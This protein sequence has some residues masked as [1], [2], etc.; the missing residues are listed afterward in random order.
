VDFVV[1]QRWV[2][3]AE[4]ELGLGLVSR[5]EGRRVWLGFPAAGTER[6][7]ALASAPIK[8]VV[9]REGDEVSDGAGRVLR[10]ESVEE[11]NGLL[12][13][14][15][16]GSAIREN[17]LSS[18]IRF[19]KP[20]ERLIGGLWDDNRAFELRRQA[21]ELHHAIARS[22]AKGFL[23]AR[24]E[25]VPHQLYIAQEVANRSMPRALL[26]DEVGLGKTIEAGLIVHRLL[27]THR[28]RRVL[29]LVPD[30][31][32]HQWFVELLRRFHLSFA[33]VD[34]A[35]CDELAESQ[36]GESPFALTENVIASLDFVASDMG[37][38]RQLV[39]G[40]WDMVVVDE[41]HHLSWTPDHASPEYRIVE[42][43]AKR[44]PGL[45]LLT[46]TPEQLGEE[47]HFARLRLLDPERYPDFEAYASESAAFRKV[48]AVAEKVATGRRLTKR[49]RAA[50]LESLPHAD[51]SLEDLL[52]DSVLKETASDDGAR[53]RLLN[54]LLDR[55][56]PGRVIFRNA[57]RVLKGFPERRV[58]PAVLDW[59]RGEERGKLF[60]RLAREYASDQLDE[61]SASVSYDFSAD[62]RA[63]W[64]ADLLER[65]APDKFLVICRY[66][67]KALALHEALRKLTTTSVGL[68][69]EGLSLLQRDRNAAW[70]AD[71]DPDRSAQA[72]LCSEIGSE[73]RNFQFAHHL[74]LLDLPPGPELLEQRIG[75]LHRIG[76]SETVLIH[77]P[78]LPGS[79]Q[80]MGYRW[81]HEG[82]DALERSLPAGEYFDEIVDELRDMSL[83]H[84]SR[85]M[86]EDRTS[87]SH[88]LPFDQVSPDLAPL[89]ER[90]AA[91]R[92]RVVASLEAGRD[93]LLELGSFRP[94]VAEHLIGEIRNWDD[95][96]TL[97]EFLAMA[98]D[99]LGSE[100]DEV[101]PRTFVL[102]QGNEL[103]VES[104]P[105]LRST[106]VG[107]TSDRER[108]THQGELDFLTWDHPM[109]TGVL[110]LLVGTERGNSA[111]A[112]ANR[113][114]SEGGR[115]GFWLEAV[116]VLDVVAPPELHVERFLPPTPVRILVD[117]AGND[118][119]GRLP[120]ERLQAELV[121]GRASLRFERSDEINQAVPGLVAK[122]RARAEECRAQVI[123]DA[124]TAMART[125]TEEIDRL[126]YLAKVNDHVHSE[127]VEMRIR[128]RDGLE[129]AIRSAELRLDALR[130]IKLVE[131]SKRR[132]ARKGTV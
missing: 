76:Q 31:L 87:S 81:F 69:H 8:R 77:V 105:G 82:L 86:E 66:R 129:R 80:E 2:S 94:D 20:E 131:P 97:D 90:T 9:F 43:L 26:A 106:E 49:D 91:L 89:L 125:M 78:H 119:T 30:A 7:Y 108:A 34:K 109:V 12:V 102:R 96:R 122:A 54:E 17:E 100:L 88:H 101:G 36:P 63:R 83:E 16:H 120:S 68:F 99:F 126:V 44:V 46:A 84:V 111:V 128:E 29:I 118:I 121:D 73:G 132:S 123:D 33:I 38:A 52:S 64:L 98:L 37:L 124:A 53:T 3:E 28:I 114:R 48:A 130:L 71:E 18:E 4:P 11:T 74:V 25:L 72:L 6:Q 51:R 10:I 61:E 107:M 70:F 45:L 22:P 47:A 13:Y 39:T 62:P 58:R 27:R 92:E 60:S 116:F 32:V 5:I 56:G 41:A 113:P 35:H 55:H 59:P 93:R 57:R 95:S 115:A 104:L 112:V 127:E 75:R 23:G 110:E 15:G 21:L 50:L 85:A 103:I 42:A 40:D 19:S 117:G 14:R 1:G 65:S 24:I 79:A 67:A